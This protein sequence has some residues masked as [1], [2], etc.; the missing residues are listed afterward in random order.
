MST[1]NQSKLPNIS[2]LYEQ[3]DLNNFNFSNTTNQ[4]QSSNKLWYTTASALKYKIITTPEE[5]KQI[6]DKL[7]K[8]WM[9]NT[10]DEY[11]EKKYWEAMNTVKQDEY[12]KQYN[13]NYPLNYARMKNPKVDESEELKKRSQEILNNRSFI[14]NIILKNIYHNDQNIDRM[15][16]ILWK[17]TA[18]IKWSYNNIW[19]W[20]WYKDIDMRIQAFEDEE[21]AVNYLTA[22]TVAK[23]IEWSGNL[24]FAITDIIYWFSDIFK[25]LFN[26]WSEQINIKES[27]N[28]K[29][30]QCYKNAIYKKQV[31]NWLEDTEYLI[32]IKWRKVS[33]KDLE[34]GIYQEVLKNSKNVLVYILSEFFRK[35][36]YFKPAFSTKESNISVIF[37]TISENIN[38]NPISK[39]DK[40]TFKLSRESYDT[41]DWQEVKRFEIQLIDWEK[42][43]DFSINNLISLIN[44]LKT[45]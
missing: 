40:S 4:S 26:E 30:Y 11:I 16:W 45:I 37:D 12:D 14:E 27:V 39:K 10:L 3:L 33:K 22:E 8:D 1:K 36:R 42:V 9:F 35:M 21:Q 44:T 7:F 31:E 24:H 43:K 32:E 29:L 2:E 34:F 19:F 23:F 18:I 41:E 13:L 38:W 15:N 25:Y 5:Q 17:A 28:H 6:I 20:K